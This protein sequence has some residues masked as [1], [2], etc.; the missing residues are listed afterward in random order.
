MRAF[1]AALLAVAALLA[2][3]GDTLVD[4]R[5][6]GIQE[7][8]GGSVC[9]GGDISC[10]VNPLPAD[11][12]CVAEDEN[13]CGACVDCTVGFTPPHVAAVPAC[14]VA[15]APGT[16]VCSFACTGGLLRC[17]DTCCAVTGVAAGGAHTCAITSDGGL[18]CWG[19]DGDGQVTGLPPTPGRSLSTPSRRY[20]SGVTAVAAGTAHTCAVLAGEVVCWGRNLEGQAPATVPQASGATALAAGV[21]HTCALVADQVRCWG[22]SLQEQIGGGTPVSSGATAIAAGADHTCALRSSG[23]VVCWGANAGGELGRG[24]AGAPSAAPV[25]ALTAGI[26]SIGAG[27]HHTCAATGSKDVTPLQCWGANPVGG[28]GS[29]VLPGLA[30][31]QTAPA[32]PQKA[33]GGQLVNFAVAKIGGGRLHTCVQRLGE[34]V[35]CFGAEGADGQLGGAL[36]PNERVD[37]GAVPFGALAM[38]VGG[39]HACAVYPD[40]TVHCWGRN[41]AGQLGDGTSITPTPGTVVAVS[42]R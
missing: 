15:G 31:P 34:N 7:D 28:D 16:G 12:T 27:A 4:H 19:D 17:E 9:S 2:G 20:G 22:S 38:A 14:T 39:D 24:T 18:S 21:A 36:V 23:A 10:Q 33:S 42:G 5:N 25:T 13:H 6:V 40:G 32:E 26:T 41:S 30:D 11:P 35:A 1:R 37:V 3:C 29:A 8:G